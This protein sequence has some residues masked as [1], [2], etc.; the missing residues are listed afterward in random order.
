MDSRSVSFP[1]SRKVKIKKAD[2]HVLLGRKPDQ[3]FLKTLREKLLW[4]T[5]KRN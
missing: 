5:D 1:A 2:F 4:G 3:P